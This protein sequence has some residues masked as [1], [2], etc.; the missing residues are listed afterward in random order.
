MERKVALSDLQLFVS[1]LGKSERPQDSLMETLGITASADVRHGLISG[2]AKMAFAESHAVN[3]FSSFIVGRCEVRNAVRHGSGFQL[4]PVAEA[5]ARSGNMTAFKTAFRDM[6][7]RFIKRGGEFYVIARITS[8]SEE[9]QTTLAASLHAEYNGLATSGSVSAEFKNATKETHN[10]TEV[11]VS[12]NQA[13]GIGSQ[14]SFTGMDALKVLER[15]SQF[16]QIAHEHPVAYEV[17]LATYDTI[18]IDVAPPEER[19]DRNTVLRDCL[20]QKMGFLKPCQICNSCSVR[21][22]RCFFDDLPPNTE[23]AKMEGHYRKALNSL[24]AHA[25]ESESG[26]MNP[27][28]MFEA[29]RF[30]RQ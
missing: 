19:E 25:I 29:N 22:E 4:T 2:G 26:R 18:P 3:S 5:L 15:L 16:P 28:Q 30:H 7:V 27:P 10:R 9:H 1:F 21:V 6:F 24:M 20:P 23:L 14:L 8:S 13:G 17:E 12:M 11:A